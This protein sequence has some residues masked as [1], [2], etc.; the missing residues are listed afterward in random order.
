MR[1]PQSVVGL[2]WIELEIRRINLTDGWHTSSRPSLLYLVQKC[3]KQDRFV[4]ELKLRNDG[5]EGCTERRLKPE[6]YRMDFVCLVT[7]IKIYKNEERKARHIDER[8]LPNNILMTFNHFYCF[9]I[10][11]TLCHPFVHQGGCTYSPE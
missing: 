1:K 4:A 5:L 10:I 9:F 3:R 8:T 7:L 11:I 2:D 6:M